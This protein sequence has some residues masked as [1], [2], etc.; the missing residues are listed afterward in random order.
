ML[1]GS[2]WEPFGDYLGP[3]H[4]AWRRVDEL[5][6]DILIVGHTHMPMAERVN[7]TLIVNPGSLG[8][9]RQHDDRRSTYA[10]VY[11]ATRTAEIRRLGDH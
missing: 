3:R 5:G 11:T 8:E 7:G 4:P 1:H 6:T 9:P 10:L 2:P